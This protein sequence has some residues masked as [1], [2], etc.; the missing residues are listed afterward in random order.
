MQDYF[1][2]FLDK[3]KTGEWMIDQNKF[4]P[5]LKKFLLEGYC[6]KNEI[7]SLFKNEGS[8]EIDGHSKIIGKTSIDEVKKID[9]IKPSEEE[10]YNYL[11]NVNRLIEKRGKNIVKKLRR[12]SCFN[13]LL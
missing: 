7:V 3:W 13:R 9:L 1:D 12:L 2:L 10:L 5:Y 6:H 8:Q 11:C 4:E